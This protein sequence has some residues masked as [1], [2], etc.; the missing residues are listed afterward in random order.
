MFQGSSAISRISSS[1]IPERK[2]GGRENSAAV[3]KEYNVLENGRGSCRRF[4]EYR[5]RLP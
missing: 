2:G 1:R 5:L 4:T 3:L